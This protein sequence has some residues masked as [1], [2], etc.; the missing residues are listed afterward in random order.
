[1]YGATRFRNDHSVVW[2]SSSQPGGVEGQSRGIVPDA[3][4]DV[5]TVNVDTNNVSKYRG[6]NGAHLGVFPIGFRPYS[7]S[8]FSGSS[9]LQTNLIGT[10][11]AEHADT[12]RGNKNPT[13][14]WNSGGSGSVLVEVAGS[15]TAGSPG[16]FVPAPNGV[17]VPGVAGKYISIRVTL[18]AA[19]QV[20]PFVEDLTLN[21]CPQKGDFNDDC[22][23]D[24]ADL[25]IM[26]NAYNMKPRPTD[27]KWDLNGDGKFDIAD[28]RME[29]L[30][31]CYPGGAACGCCDE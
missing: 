29:V 27:P 2:S 1:M 25:T 10:W 11:T 8:D 3:N 26:R 12:L 9:F 5:F 18:Q 13:V 17:Q 6:S 14:S 19:N 7:Y 30:L 16:S 22:C 24:L 4:G 20:S 21:T 31:F 28:L 15:D 23:N